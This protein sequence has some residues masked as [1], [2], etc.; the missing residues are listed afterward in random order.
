VSADIALVVPRPWGVGALSMRGA[1]ILWWPLT[2]DDG[3]ERA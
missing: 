1:W 2:I 3:K